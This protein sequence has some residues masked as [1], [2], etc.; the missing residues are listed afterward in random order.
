MTLGPG[1]QIGPYEILIL[2]GVGGMGEVYK[3]RDKRLDRLVAV[4]VLSPALRHDGPE[5]ER[6][7]REARAIARLEHPNIC[8]LHDVGRD[9]EVEYL[10]M[11]YIEGETLAA[12]I[13]RKRGGLPFTEA[14]ELASQI[15]SALDTAHRAGIVHRDLKPAN[16]MITKTGVKLLDFGLAKLKAPTGVAGAVTATQALTLTG[17]NTVLGTLQYMAPVQ[18]EGREADARSDIFSFG[19][20][21]YE[22]LS[23]RR[24]FDGESP[25][26]VI[27]A[28]L[29]SEPPSLR[30]IR[31]TA[32]ASVRDLVNTCLLKDPEARWQTVSDLRH[33]LRLAASE[34]PSAAQTESNNRR[35]Y[36]RVV[37][38]AAIAACVVTGWLAIARLSK[39]T[40]PAASPLLLTLDLP[41]AQQLYVEESSNPLPSLT[42]SPDGRRLVYVSDRDGVPHLILRELN[43]SGGEFIAGTEGAIHPVF[44]PDGQWI[45]FHS[46]GVLKRMPVGGGAAVPIR[47]MVWLRGLTWAADG[48]IFASTGLYEGIVR[49]PLDGG[50]PKRVTLLNATAGE[51]THRWPDLLPNG[52]AIVFTVGIGQ[53]WDDARIDAQVLSTGERRRLINGGMYPRYVPTGHLVYVHGSDLM[54]VSFDPEEIRVTGQPTKVLGDVLGEETGAAQFTFSSGGTLVVAPSAV[55]GDVRALVWVER[56]GGRETPVPGE[57]AGYVLPRLS[58]DGRRVLY[59]NEKR[60]LYI[61]DLVRGASLGVSTELRV[62]SFTTWTSDGRRVLFSVEKDGQWDIFAKRADGMGAEEKLFVDTRQRSPH[63]ASRDGRSLAYN[64]STA[65]GDQVCILTLGGQESR[66]LTRSPSRK[67]SFRFSPDGRYIAYVDYESGQSEIFVVSVAG[68]DDRWLISAQGALHPTW[69]MDGRELFFIQG[70]RM[71]AVRVT[72]QPAFEASAPRQLFEGNYSRDGYDI[73]PDGRFLM[74]KPIEHPQAHQLRVVVNWFEELKRLVPTK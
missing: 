15:T 19:C 29:G 18:L 27:T 44:S 32:L 5:R 2:L 38:I 71:M 54:A 69:S 20:V 68:S 64:E 28:V 1:T 58:P 74:L 42:L 8:V 34:T 17:P 55:A 73:G 65:E 70:H 52:R 26:G 40:A 4:K 6:F 49:L 30:E 35:T 39:P 60:Q 45:V 22:M 33:G 24:P 59:V 16:I 3:A 53:S 66:C 61:R 7:E 72:T 57:P 50:E 43:R 36:F 9:G 10:V 31:P 62:N 11:E 67:D 25:A 56:N 47:R 13:A 41:Q 23:G 63:D 37:L 51:R 12:R 48:A 14:F 21:L 46:G